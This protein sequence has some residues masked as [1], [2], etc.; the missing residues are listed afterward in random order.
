MSANIKDSALPDLITLIQNNRDETVAQPQSPQP[1]NQSIDSQVGTA[2]L[3]GEDSI[4]SAL[5]QRGAGELLN[6]LKWDSYPEKILIL[7]A[8]HEARGGTTPWKSS[9]MEDLFNQAKEKPPGNFPR[10]IT[11]SIKAGLVHATTPRTYTITRTG[12]NKLGQA[13]SSQP[14]G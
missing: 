12:W 3:D 7:G 4:K 1:A 10:D 14:A 11:K 6:Q 5:K 2:A 13:L 9:D 8:W